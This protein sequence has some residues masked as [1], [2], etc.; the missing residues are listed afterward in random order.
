MTAIAADLQLYVK[1]EKEY[2]CSFP[3]SLH[4]GAVCSYDSDIFPSVPPLLATVTSMKSEVR[5]T[6]ERITKSNLI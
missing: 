6:K 4:T 1:I 2:Q 3:I 5:F